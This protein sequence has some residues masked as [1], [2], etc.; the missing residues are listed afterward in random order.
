MRLKDNKITRLSFT[1]PGFN[2]IKSTIL[3]YIKLMRPALFTISTTGFTFL[4]R[5]G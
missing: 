4:R 5:V 3:A 1:L 2:L